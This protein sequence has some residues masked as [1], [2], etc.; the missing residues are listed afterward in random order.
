MARPQVLGTPN[1]SDG[2]LDAGDEIS[3]TYNEDIR[4]SI[5]S[6]GDNFVIEAVLN[7]AEVDHNVALK[8]D[9]TSNFAAATEASI[10]LAN[11][12]FTVDMWVNLSSGGT[13]LKHG[14]DKEYFTVSV[15]STGK[16]T[17]NV[18]GT[19]VTSSDKIPFNKWCF[20]TLSY[21]LKSD[22]SAAV[23]ALVAYDAE[24]VSL[25]VDKKL[26]KY[27]ATETLSLGK[28]IRGAIGEVALWGTKRSNAESQSQM[29]FA[30]SASTENLIGY[31]KFN[32]GHGK[33]AKDVARSRNMALAADSWYLNNTN[34]A[35]TLD[36]KSQLSLDITRSTALSSD[37][38]MMEMWFR[39][40]SQ[41]NATLW[42]ANTKVALKFNAN[43]YLTLLTD[44]VENQL[45]TANYLDGAW[46]HVA[47]NVL[48]NGTTTIYMDG[49][50]VKQL[51]SSKVP[52]LQASE[53]T[54]GAQRYSPSYAVYDYTDF[55]KGDVDEVRYW[56]ATFNAKAIEQFRY[57]RLNGDEAGLEAY[58]PFEDITKDAGIT[59]YEFALKDM[60]ANAIGKAKGTA[61]K[62]ASAPAL[63][64][65]PNMSKLNYSFVASERTVDITLN[66][67]ASR[68]EGT[69]VNFTVKNVRD[70]NNNFSLPVTWS[71]YINQ[72][73]LIWGDDAISLEK[74][75]EDETSFSLSVVNQGAA[76]ESWSI[77][78]LP[79]WLTASKNNGSLSALKSETI[80]FEI[81]NA[82]PTGSYEE[83][84]Y[85][86]GNEGISVPFTIN[87]KVNVGKP[88]W[89]VDPSQFENSMSVIAQLK[90]DG[91]YST[92]TEDLV[93]AFINGTCVGVASPKYYSRYDAYFVS[94]DIYGNSTDADK[95]VVFKAWDAS[96]G[97]TYPTLSTSSNIKFSSNALFGS[98]KEP[99]ILSSNKMQEQNLDLKKGWNW[100]SLN[101]KPSNDSINA[102]F[103]DIANK[104][105]ILKSKTNFSQSNGKEFS[106]A[107]KNVKIGS[108]YKAQMNTAIN[109]QVAGN[110]ID[111]SKETVT[112]KSGWN[113]IGFNST[114][115]MSLNEAFADL[116]PVDGDMVKGQSG[117][118][119]YEGYEW[120]G[121]LTALN[122]GKGYMYKS[123]AKDNRSFKYPAKTSSL[124]A[125]ISKETTKET[126][127]KTENETAY[128]GNMTIVA[129]VKDGNKVLDDVQI[130]IFDA[131]GKC[132]AAAATDDKSLAFLTVMGGESA[133]ALTI[134]VIYNGYEYVLEQDLVY[135]DDA[136]LGTLSN[137]YVIQLTPVDAITDVLNTSISVYPTL[138]ETELNVK[139]ESLTVTN[140]SISDIS[141]R[142]LINDEPN[143]SEFTINVSSLSQGA[144]ILMMETEAGTIIKR[145]S[146]K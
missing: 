3:V 115:T 29:H 46:H 121:T 39:G 108:M 111:A 137:P 144:Y 18:N 22:S 10:G 103:G 11:K 36:G 47:M 8:M 107:L 28:N 43:G 19:K 63:Q 45:S 116:N 94:L 89:S 6:K 145:F 93:A 81:S 99:V 130:G 123:V 49:S 82:V 71:A 12:S 25:L 72:N 146:K 122:P 48:R 134:K 87:L 41:K 85:L 124:R 23:S 120:V 44:S 128:S 17:V 66:E 59:G 56:V 1:P 95:K 54:I 83:T 88:D 84:I 101:V 76:T 52:A 20:L 57:I 104:A 100:I 141:G 102:V 97:V 118:A 4:N 96:T 53:L 37:D 34:F 113:W 138:V 132:R 75:V 7:D 24:E 26:P 42:S 32:E 129:V 74:N 70:A 50:I 139:A 27:G 86:V 14:S 2:I 126:A 91:N 114:T 142:I 55:F 136:T 31:W 16:L 109:Y 77:S 133:D 106:G 68:L 98:M 21:N 80:E 105:N 51:S 140:Y 135:A 30:K 62:A 40:N 35:A 60:S 33:V 92:D 15:A 127:Y 110:A 90:L 38:Y 5:L 78:N 131:K 79:S 64:A 65:K 13:L 119:Y 67:N 125:L 69:T 73:R 112:I 117:F 143:N 9:S 61:K 58:Y